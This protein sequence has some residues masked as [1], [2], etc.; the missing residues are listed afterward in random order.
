[1][2]RLFLRTACAAAAV[3]LSS[4]TLPAQSLSD[5]AL[6]Y[7]PVPIDAV[8]CSN[9]ST[10]LAG[11]YANGVDLGYDGSSG[12]VDLRTVNLHRY[13]VFIVPSL[14]DNATTTPYAFLRDGV[15]SARLRDVLLGRFAMWSGT[16]DLGDASSPNRTQKNALISSLATW[17]GA[18]YTT[19][20]APGLVTFLDQSETT[21]D[22]YNWMQSI[23]RLTVIPDSRVASYESVTAQ[24]ATGTEILTSGGSLLSYPNMASFGFQLP[25]GATGVSLDAV[26]QAATP[27]DGQVV[28]LTSPGSN[29]GVVANTVDAFVFA[30]PND[31]QIFAGDRV[32]PSLLHAAKVVFIYTTSGDDS[33]DE[34]YY[35]PK[36]GGARAGADAIVPGSPD[37]PCNPQIIGTHSI[38]R[39]AR[40]NM[41]HYYLR[42]HDGAGLEQLRDQGPTSA[43]DG[44]T[45]YASFADL[46]QTIGAIVDHEA[47]GQTAPVVTVHASEYDRSRIDFDHPD[48]IANG[49]AVKAASATHTWNLAWY[50]GYDTQHNAANLPGTD[51][52]NKLREFA[53]YD[54]V[55]Q[56]AGFPS[57]FSDFVQTL[58]A[59]TYF[60]LDH[61]APGAQPPAAPLNLRA[62]AVSRS[63]SGG[64]T[65]RPTRR[66]LASNATRALGCG[67]RS[68][69]LPPTSRRT[70]T[71]DSLPA[72]STSTACGRSMARVAPTRTSGA[73]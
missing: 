27:G 70:A 5:K 69:P 64:S 30:H 34:S 60:R 8:G 41:A 54:N 44:S 10:A 72:A 57:E 40:G 12:T 36:E 33:R 17:A 66:A 13:K 3:C 62:Q 14:A 58:I 61:S 32:A 23:A 11:R 21:T 1:M 63:I 22:R 9:I 31:W 51:F 65:F 16:P 47:A 56:D 20:R 67:R 43:I 4:L 7:C 53:G 59:R 68:P 50:L 15:V 29:T 39:C 46:Y 45:T 25:L 2:R 26:G 37:W 42:L 6:I 73:Q 71:R 35:L 49:D 38:R 48:H 24:T 55:I 52:Q 18:N 19:V 28:L